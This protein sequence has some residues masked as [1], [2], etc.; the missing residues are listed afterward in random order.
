[1]Q[2]VA[3]RCSVLQCVAVCCSVLQCV[4]GRCSV[5]QCVAVCVYACLC[6]CVCVIMSVRVHVHVSMFVQGM[7]PSLTVCVRGGR[8]GVLV[9]LSQNRAFLKKVRIRFLSDKLLIAQ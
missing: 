5:L 6:V 7:P 3:V 4:A 8:G 2:C 9:K 1:L